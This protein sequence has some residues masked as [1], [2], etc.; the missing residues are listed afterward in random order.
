MSMTGFGSASAEGEGLRASVECRSVNGRYLKL[1]I[2]LPDA[3]RAYEAKVEK[4]LKALLQRG[5][6]TLSVRFE[7]TDLEAL[8]SVNEDVVRAYRSV[9]ERLDLPVSAIPSLPG[10]LGGNR[11]E[12]S[13]AQVAVVD[14]A[15]GDALEAMVAMRNREG[16]ALEVHLSEL[17]DSVAALRDRV[18]E[19]APAVVAEYRDR[20]ADRVRQLLEGSPAELDDT[21]LAREV[22]VFASRCDVTEEVE[23]IASHLSQIREVLQGA[24]SAGR[25]LDFLGQ[26]LHR[27]VN[28]IGSKS[29]DT[30]LAR[31]VIELK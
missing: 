25:T 23:R 4:R 26:E 13:D 6:V 9:F 12:L 31:I 7:R 21:T 3:L 20:L 18:L 8:V 15:I 28:T 17:V 29:S 14:Q 22:A 2:R 24:E 27:E 1:N 16:Q 10:V 11:V 19:R 5:S 30:E